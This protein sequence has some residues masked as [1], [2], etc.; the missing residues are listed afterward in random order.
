MVT[1]P[2]EVRSR[3]YAVRRERRCAELRTLTAE[4]VRIG[5]SPFLSGQTIHSGRAQEKGAEPKPRALLSAV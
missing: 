2:G 3:A 1:C 5:A 4:G